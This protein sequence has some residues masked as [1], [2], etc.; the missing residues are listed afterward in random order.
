MEDASKLKWEGRWDQVK[1]KAREMWG[2]LTDDDVDVAEGNV[3][4]LIGK[5]KERTGE[6][7]ETI[8][9]RLSRLSD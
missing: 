1:G 5:I 7:A 6:T 2:E 4:Q 3:E 8:R 9:E